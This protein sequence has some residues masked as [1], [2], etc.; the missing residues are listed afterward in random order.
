VLRHIGKPL[1]EPN[2]S[3]EFIIVGLEK[4][5]AYN[6]ATMV[7]IDSPLAPGMGSRLTENRLWRTFPFVREGRLRA[8]PTVLGSGG[9]PSVSRFARLLT[10]ALDDK[11][12]VSP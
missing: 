12:G 3:G 7:L 1:A 10:V 2:I 11:S 9:L 5:G 6:D 8:I 4:L